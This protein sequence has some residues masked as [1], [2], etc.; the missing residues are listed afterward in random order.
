MGHG[1]QD[2]G[3]RTS[4]TLPTLPEPESSQTAQLRRQLQDQASEIATLKARPAN[5]CPHALPGPETQ[6]NHFLG[7]ACA[8]VELD[9]H[10]R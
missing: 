2:S 5:P 3:R 6:P 10:T 4:R 8:C 9:A 1:V 7:T